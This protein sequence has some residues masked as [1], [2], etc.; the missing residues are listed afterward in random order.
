MQSVI[1]L[2]ITLIFRKV[3]YADLIFL[4]L[5]PYPAI[6]MTSDLSMRIHNTT[7]FGGNKEENWE[8]WI[9]RFETRFSNVDEKTLSSVLLDV[10]DGAALDV[11]GKLDK[12]ARRDYKKIDGSPAKEIWG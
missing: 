12:E 1:R 4:N 11:C 6:T 10:L 7:K 9:F 5:R 8:T 2:Y 3:C